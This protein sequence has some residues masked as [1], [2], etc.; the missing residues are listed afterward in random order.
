[1]TAGGFN[2][3]DNEWWHFDMLDRSHVRQRFLRVD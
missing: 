3:I 1:M 2:G